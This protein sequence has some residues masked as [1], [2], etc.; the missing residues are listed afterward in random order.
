M[1]TNTVTVSRPHRTITLVDLENL[2]AEARTQPTRA[3]K[4][5]LDAFRMALAPYGPNLLVV[6]TGPSLLFSARLV[7]PEARL[8]LGRGVDGA[9]LALLNACKDV[10]HMSQRFDRFIV[11]S[12]DGIFAER[13]ASM[14]A[15]GLE[16]GVI[17]QPQCLARRL[18][19]AACWTTPL[20]P[21]AFSR[22]AA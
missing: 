12:G 10:R 7:F 21:R 6:G 17:S 15:A 16:V 8:V 5:I 11:A 2:L 20:H 3:W 18:R 9:D 4:P 14:V 1:K 13:A 22:T 19:K